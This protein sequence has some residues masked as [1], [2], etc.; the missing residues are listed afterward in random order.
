MNA[1]TR[2]NRGVTLLKTEQV[3]SV[4]QMY[5]YWKFPKHTLH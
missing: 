1:L 5:G 2:V 4:N 3:Q